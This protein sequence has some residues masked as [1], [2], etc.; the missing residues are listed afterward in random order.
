V[1]PLLACCLVLAG[2]SAPELSRPFPGTARV[3]IE[4]P[5][6]TAPSAPLR[7]AVVWNSFALQ[8]GFRVMAD[9]PVEVGTPVT[10]QL[11]LPEETVK[12]Q[13]D[14]LESVVL[15]PTASALAYR[16]R[17]LVYA[18]EDDDGSFSP[19][20]PGGD[21][22][23]RVL[24][25]DA[26]FATSVTAL[27]DLD[28]A[29]SSLSPGEAARLYD[30]N[31][32]RYSAFVWT[33][34]SPYGR[35]IAP[36]VDPLV[37][38]LHDSSVPDE[39]FACRRQLPGV[40][41]GATGE[42]GRAT[43]AI[44][45]RALDSAAVCGIQVTDCRTEDLGSVDP[46]FLEVDAEGETLHLVQCRRSGALEF[47]LVLDVVPECVDCFCEFS[48]TA[49]LFVAPRGVTPPWWPCGSSTFPYCETPLPA[50]Q[51]DLDCYRN[52]LGDGGADGDMSDG[53]ARESG[54]TDAGTSEA[55]RPDASLDGRSPG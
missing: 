25:I 42:T 49:V 39:D 35:V 53:G 31:G 1:R 45:D 40:A 16:P 7:Y 4:D 36:P 20:A 21:G 2:C 41:G 22:P 14:P 13:A 29:L 5:L 48:R 46:P 32:G 23:D 12:R 26:T 43:T 51:F 19:A 11:D 52:A 55:G 10:V 44:V 24:A 47:L 33:E 30:R 3:Q 15:T 17:F 38:A 54:P 9:G 50:S 8:G 37:L 28:R 27:V 34:I 18:D 6:Q